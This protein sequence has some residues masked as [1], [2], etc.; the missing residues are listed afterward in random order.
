MAKGK[1]ARAAVLSKKDSQAGV[2]SD[3]MQ[4]HWLCCRLTLFPKA[5]FRRSDVK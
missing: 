5:R 3:V 4:F 2:C 1:Q